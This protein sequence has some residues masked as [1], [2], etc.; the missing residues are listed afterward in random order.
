MRNLILTFVIFGSSVISFASQRFA[1]Q[2]DEDILTYMEEVPTDASAIEAI[3]R[4]QFQPLREEGEIGI[5][6]DVIVN[7]GKKLWA[8]VEANKPVV[9]IKHSYANALPKGVIS[10]DTLQGF[11]EVQFRSLRYSGKNG[12]GNN[13]FDVT[14]TLVHRYGGNYDGEGSYLENVTVLPQKVEVLW[15]YNLSMSVD[16]IS[17]VNVGTKKAPVASL[18]MQVNTKVSTVIKSSETH[19]VFS[20]RGDSSKVTSPILDGAAL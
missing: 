2:L 18:L 13:V 4:T 20:F 8:F 12:F 6:I 14:Y 10:S 16:S 19:N 7:L 1:G 17:T 15:G 9:D 11:S 3:R 5:I